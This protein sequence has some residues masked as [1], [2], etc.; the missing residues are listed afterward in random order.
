MAEGTAGRGAAG[1][2]LGLA[3][4]AMAVAGRDAALSRDGKW[5]LGDSDGP[6]DETDGAHVA[7]R[8]PRAPRRAARVHQEDAHNAG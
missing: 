4:C 5:S 8:L 7:L 1:D 3:A 2:R 6:A